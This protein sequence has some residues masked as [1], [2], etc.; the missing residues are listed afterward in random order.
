MT[1]SSIAR[2]KHPGRMISVPQ[3]SRQNARRPGAQIPTSQR[4]FINAIT[5]LFEIRGKGAHGR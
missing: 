5:S 3:K 4:H 1:E 2:E